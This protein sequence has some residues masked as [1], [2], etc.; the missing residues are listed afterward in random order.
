VHIHEWPGVSIDGLD[1]LKRWMDAV[2]ARPAVQRGV[3]R[4]PRQNAEEQV[5]KAKSILV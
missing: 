1:H 4:P 3:Q 2:T 5:Q